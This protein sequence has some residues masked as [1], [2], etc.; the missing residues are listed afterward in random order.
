M[1]EV[2]EIH[3]YPVKSC[4]GIRLQSA[5]LAST[6]LTW[7]RQWMVVDHKG[8]FLTQR[9]FP[10]FSKIDISL[11]IEALDES[12]MPL[13][14]ESALCVKAPDMEPLDVPLL[15]RY[16]REKIEVAVWGWTGKGFDEGDT[17]SQWFSKYLGKPGLRLVRFDNANELR[18]TDPKYAPGYKTAFSDGYPILLISEASLESL[19]SKLQV[20]ILMN[21]FRP[22]VVVKGCEPFDEDLWRKFTIGEHSFQGVNICPRCKIPTIDPETSA[23]GREPLLALKKFRSGSVLETEPSSKGQMFFGQNVVSEIKEGEH[24]TI[25]IGDLVQVAVRSTSVRELMAGL[26]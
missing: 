22:N 16:E 3:V 4:R 21:R 17:P 13:G 23:V 20:P 19:N 10:T 18:E 5:N 1:V 26:V 12:W 25:R 11:P 2:S 6:G 14:P 9:Q 8:V 7:D 15:P 24:R